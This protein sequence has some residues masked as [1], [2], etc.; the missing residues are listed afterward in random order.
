M[1][2]KI[3]LPKDAKIHQVFHISLL[4]IYHQDNDIHPTTLPTKFT[5]GKPIITP[6]KILNIKRLLQ[7]NQYITKLL[8]HWEGLQLEDASWIML[9]G[10]QRAYPSFNFEDKVDCQEGVMIR[11]NILQQQTN[12]LCQKPHIIT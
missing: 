7:Y 10:L 9:I 1:A 5:E 8:V 12:S 6:I 3:K 11:S 4:K 2:Y